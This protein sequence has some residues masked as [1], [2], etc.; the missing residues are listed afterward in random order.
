MILTDLLKN[1]Q[2]WN[3]GKSDKMLVKMK[4]EN[5]WG[6][7]ILVFSTVEMAGQN[8]LMKMQIEKIEE[9]QYVATLNI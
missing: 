2:S 1:S 9:D 5:I 3:A 7:P 4:M 6:E 8:F